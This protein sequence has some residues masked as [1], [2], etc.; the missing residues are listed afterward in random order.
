MGTDKLL[1]GI[2][3]AEEFNSTLLLWS[4]IV[5][6]LCGLVLFIAGLVFTAA[7]GAV[8]QTAVYLLAL[9]LF[10]VIVGCIA[11]L[12]VRF[13]NPLLLFIV[14]LVNIALYFAMFIVVM[15][16]LRTPS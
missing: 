1:C 7:V 6:A 9:G 3:N 5:F 11:L 16:R 12:G 8:G 13:Q 14:E 10:F 15:A 4:Y 2:W